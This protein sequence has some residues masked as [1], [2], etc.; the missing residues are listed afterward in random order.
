VRNVTLSLPD[1]LYKQAR[2]KAAEQEV[3]ISGLV[4]K[5][6]TEFVQRESTFERLQRHQNETLA[7]IRRELRERGEHFDPNDRL[8]R[9]ELYD[10]AFRGH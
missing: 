7:E 8:T 9:E 6:L 2:I 10:E 5:L 3:S 4:K 1:D